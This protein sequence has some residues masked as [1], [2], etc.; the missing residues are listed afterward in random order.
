MWDLRGNKQVWMHSDIDVNEV[1]SILKEKSECVLWCM[2][3]STK[4]RSRDLRSSSEL[5][6]AC[7]EVGKK[8]K[9]NMTYE[10]KQKMVDDTVDKLR[11]KHGT[12]FTSL[13]CHVWAETILSGSHES[14]DNSPRGSFFGCKGQASKKGAC[15]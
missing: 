15:S 6:D 1:W 13:Q 5:S 9:K 11:S 14:L 3:R 10:D 12:K 7:H 2:E 8:S 4:K